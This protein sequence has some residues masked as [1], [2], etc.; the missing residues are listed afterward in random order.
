[1]PLP[2]LSGWQHVFAHAVVVIACFC[3]PRCYAGDMHGHMRGRSPRNV[4]GHRTVHGLLPSDVPP[5]PRK[6]L[7]AMSATRLGAAAAMAGGSL[8]ARSTSLNATCAA[9]NSFDSRNSFEA[10]KQL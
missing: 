7:S 3:P 10:R 1:M 2:R 5:N 4:C 6:L 8:R 9:H